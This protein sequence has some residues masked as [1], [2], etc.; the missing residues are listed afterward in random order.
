MTAILCGQNNGELIFQKEFQFDSI[1]PS[2]S[3]CSDY[4]VLNQKVDSFYHEKV[5][6]LERIADSLQNSQVNYNYDYLVKVDCLSCLSDSVVKPND[7]PRWPYD[8]HELDPCYH[9][10]I[11]LAK[12]RPF[13]FIDHTGVIFYNEDLIEK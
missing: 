12:A 2:I 9:F 6:V 3:N 7:C 13:R 5:I 8:F 4:N 1:F 10:K 11:S